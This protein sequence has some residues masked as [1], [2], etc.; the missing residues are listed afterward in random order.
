MQRAQ[1]AGA[2]G[3]QQGLGTVLG[4]DFGQA[5]CGETQG[6]VPGSGPEL[7]RAALAAADERGEDAV[8]GLLLEG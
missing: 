4:A 8:G 7:A 1:R 5:L 3:G 6:F 2:A